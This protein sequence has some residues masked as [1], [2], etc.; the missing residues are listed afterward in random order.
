MVGNEDDYSSSESSGLDEDYFF[1]DENMADCLL[2]DD[3]MQQFT[4]PPQQAWKDYSS[5][6]FPA[7]VTIDSSKHKQW[8]IAK[9]EIMHVRKQLRN[10]L[11]IADEDEGIVEKMILHLVGPNS[12]VGL[13]LKENLVLDDSK[14]LKFLHT[15]CLQAA[16]D[17]STKQLYHKNSKL[18]EHVL[19]NERGYLDIWKWMA[20]RKKLDS[21]TIK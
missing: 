3:E 2:A 1:I 6:D 15:C 11:D 8:I 18:Q 12:K 5:K 4:A 10:L 19:L 13:F 20:N 16:Y 9:K 7:L 17:C 14:Y 21:T